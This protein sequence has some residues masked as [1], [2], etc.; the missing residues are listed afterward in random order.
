[1]TT[2]CYL[3]RRI[4]RSQ[5]GMARGSSGSAPLAGPPSAAAGLDGGADG[6]GLAPG[7]CRAPTPGHPA[8]DFELQAG[9]V[10]Q[11][12][13]PPD[14]LDPFDPP[15]PLDGAPEEPGDRED[16]TGPGDAPRDRGLTK[17]AKPA[18]D[19]PDPRDQPEAALDG[20]APLDAPR[21]EELP[22]KALPF[23]APPRDGLP[24]DA[25]P[26]GAPPRDGL[27]LAADLGGRSSGGAVRPPPSASARFL[28]RAEPVGP[29]REDDPARLPREGTAVVLEP[30]LTSPS[31][32]ATGGVSGLRRAA[33]A[34]PPVACPAPA[35]AAVS[36]DD[37]DA[38]DAAAPAAAPA[39][40]ATAA[41][42]AAA[43]AGFLRA[44]R[45]AR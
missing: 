43:A 1:M 35:A 39:P 6:L 15:D 20:P 27:P 2:G 38:A 19:R 14:P 26:R 37:A 32:S 44:Q 30:E 31:P 5:N 24:F 8:E 9:L 29:A 16:P 12:P 42:A 45:A 28:D 22:L 7:R 3:S 18:D 13:D 36:P 23:D 21:C 33:C 34:S 10:G 41:A 17:P 11:D 40:P 25:P 4:G